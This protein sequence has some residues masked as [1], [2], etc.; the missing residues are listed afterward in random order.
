MSQLCAHV[1]GGGGGDWRSLYFP[2]W[3]GAGGREGGKWQERD[4]EEGRFW[5]RVI[6]GE[7]G[8][9][10]DLQLAE[11]GGAVVAPDL[12]PAHAAHKVR[13]P[14]L[15]LKGGVR[16]GSR[17]HAGERR[18]AG[19]SDGRRGG[20]SAEA[21]PP[22]VARGQARSNR[23]ISADKRRSNCNQ[24]AAQERNGQTAV[25]AVK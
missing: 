4:D 16:V 19:R 5:W 15:L 2:Q 23:D 18:M 10:A 3:R 13:E 7:Q 24:A 25:K 14:E 21:F 9:P 12:Q 22:H 17:D 20:R 11:E 8:R 6:C 1:G